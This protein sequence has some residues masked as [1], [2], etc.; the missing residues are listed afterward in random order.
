MA[1]DLYV[2]QLNIGGTDYIVKDEQARQNINSVGADVKTRFAGVDLNGR[3]LEFYDGVGKDANLLDSM[4]TVSIVEA[5]GL[6][7][8]KFGY[9]EYD[10]TNHEINF[11]DHSET[12]S[13]SGETVG[14]TLISTIDATDFIKDGM[15]QN[16][17]I[18]N[19][20]LVISFNTDA[21][22]QDISIDLDD[23]FDASNY[24]TSAEVDTLLGAKANTSSLATVATSGSYN[25]L[26]D[27]P[28]IP[29][30]QVQANWN[31][32]DTTSMAYIQ[33]KPTI[34]Q[35]VVVDSTWVQNSTNPVESQLVQTALNGKQDTLVSG[36]NVKS[37]NGTSLLGSG[38][39][40]QTVT[41]TYNSTTET[42][43]LSISQS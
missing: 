40:T 15:V 24:Y 8:S 33:N 38:N 6:L 21:G 14:H 17:V 31:E 5:S 1:A 22:K 29:A 35:G 2:K 23:I 39:I 43:T 26:T 32:T 37:L 9:V 41:G 16:V 4:S 12:D 28:S 27:K 25:D 7:D 11:Y 18:S 34:P 3:D 30:A 13:K 19:G 42:L 10:S 36:T 20:N